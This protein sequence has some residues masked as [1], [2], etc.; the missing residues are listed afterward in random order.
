MAYTTINKSTEHFNTKTWT[1]TGDYTTAITGV[2]FQPDWVWVKN[3]DVGDDHMLFDAVRG[4]T[5]RLFSNADTAEGTDAQTLTSFDSDGF[6]TGTSRATGGD[7]GNKMVAWNWKAGGAGSANTAGNTNSTVSVNTTAGFSIVKWTGTGSAT[8]VGHGLGVAPTWIIVK[9]LADAND[10]FVYTKAIGYSMSNP[11]PETDYLKLNQINGR[12]DDANAWNDTAPTNQVF[13]V[14]SA[15]NVNGSSDPMIAYCFTDKTGYCKVGSYYGNGNANGTFI[16]TG[17]KPA[18]VIT[19]KTSGNDEW[20]INDTTRDSYGNPLDANLLANTS[21]AE[22]DHDRF[23]AVSNGFKMRTDSG[24]YNASGSTY[25][26]MAFGQSLV[27]SN[28]VPCTAR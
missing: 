10:W 3:R 20:N 11:D 12:A 23:D 6:T 13:S 28:N 7:S 16:Y 5:K 14:G 21:A 8:T 17:F 24:Q 4:V 27:G 2:G 26:Y 19:K 15:S 25:I 9:N 22:T 18:F 1:G